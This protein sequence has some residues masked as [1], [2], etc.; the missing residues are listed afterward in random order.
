MK[1][2]IRFGR[3]GML[4]P[5]YGGPYEILERAGEVS[6]DLALLAELPSIHHVF[7]ISML[8][9]C[10]SDPASIL[11]VECLGLMKT[12]LMRRYLVRS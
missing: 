6:Y 3:K 10:L 12:C 4:S 11:P 9:K 8:K 7:H 2:V 1:G 5:R